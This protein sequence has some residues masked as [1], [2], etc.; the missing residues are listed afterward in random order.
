M[1]G[2]PD[3]IAHFVGFAGLLRRAGFAVAPEQT[4]S[5]L[6]A[7]ELLGPQEIGDIRRA[8]R[9]TLAPPPER[10]AEFDALFDAH[11][12]GV[13]GSQVEL[14]PSE[15]E[16]IRAAE[17][18][19][20]GPEPIFGD[21][22]HE[23]GAQATTAERL[24][25]APFRSRAGGRDAA[26]LRPRCFRPCAAAPRLSLAVSPRRTRHGRTTHVPRCHASRWRDFQLASAQAASAATPH[27]RS[28]RRFRV[29]EGADASPSGFCACAGSRRRFGRSFHHRHAADAHNPAVAPEESRTGAHH[30]L[31]ACCR[32]GW[33]HP[34][35]R[36][37]ERISCGPA[38]LRIGARRGAWSYCRMGWSAA[39]RRRWP[40]QSCVFHGS[41]GGSF[42]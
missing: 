11:F 12:L 42:G 13:F 24:C 37:V 19:S 41:R 38:F 33:R 15:D 35:R 14:V 29:D 18:S 4:V 36:G 17:D 39:I 20:I 3:P 22:T 28:R 30:R 32:L 26:A 25:G 27:R 40:M 9:A 8:A 34:H 1:N 6:A 16:P 23:F 2:P 21:E 7:I 10:F 5:W 31:A